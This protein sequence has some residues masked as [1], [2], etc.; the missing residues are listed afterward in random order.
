MVAVSDSVRIDKF[1]GRARHHKNPR[2]TTAGD[3]TST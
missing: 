3:S 2:A 1:T